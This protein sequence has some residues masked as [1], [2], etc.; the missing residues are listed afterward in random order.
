MEDERERFMRV[1][2]EDSLAF[3][4]AKMIRRVLGLAH[5]E[6][7]ESI[8][9]AERRALCESKA[10]TLAASLSSARRDFPASPM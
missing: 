5:T 1:L 9:D 6:D 7:L 10:L 4:G 8:A 2:F 3:G